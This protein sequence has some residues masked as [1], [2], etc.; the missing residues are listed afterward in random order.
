MTLKSIHGVQ[1]Y[2]GL[3]DSGQDPWRALLDKTMTVRLPVKSDE[4]FDYLKTYL[5]CQKNS[6]DG[7]IIIII[8]II[9]ITIIISH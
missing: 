1:R 3:S 7:I 4:C 8:I 5:S 2:N 6:T 9:I